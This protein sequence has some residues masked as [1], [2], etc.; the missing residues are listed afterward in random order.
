MRS[1]RV[2]RRALMMRIVSAHSV[3][4]TATIL[5]RSVAPISAWRSFIH[6][7]ARIFDDSAESIC[8]RGSLERY[9]MLPEIRGGFA[10]VP[11]EAQRHAA[12][13]RADTVVASSFR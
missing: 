9:A 6:G 2:T 7:V 3:N 8:E 4:I 1:R 11:F 10:R 12:C 13:S 5:P